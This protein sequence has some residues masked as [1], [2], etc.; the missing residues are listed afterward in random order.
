[1]MTDTPP[2]PTHLRAGDPEAG[3]VRLYLDGKLIVDPPAVEADE[4]EGWADILVRGD[5]G[6]LI[7]GDGGRFLTE[8]VY[9]FIRFVWPS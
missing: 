2:R 1:M 3:E 7:I 4:A 5:H 6:K 8:R 9:G